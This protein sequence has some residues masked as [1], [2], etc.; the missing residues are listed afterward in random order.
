MATDANTWFM[1]RLRRGGLPKPPKGEVDQDSRSMWLHSSDQD[2]VDFFFSERAK[3]GA[4]IVAYEAK[5]QLKPHQIIIAEDGLPAGV[6]YEGRA[7]FFVKTKDGRIG[8]GLDCSERVDFGTVATPLSGLAN[9]L[10]KVYVPTL[11]PTA[12]VAVVSGAMAAPVASHTREFQAS[13]QKFAAHTE[14]TLQQT[15]G[16]VT[17]TVPD[18][19][20]D[21]PAAVT[22]DW[23]ICSKLEVALEEW[24][25]VIS[26][27][28]G[29]ETRKQPQ[30]EGPLS[31]IEFWQSRNGVLSSLTEQL[32]GQS[33]GKMLKVLELVEASSLPSFK[34]HYSELT[35]LYIEA[36]D[37]VK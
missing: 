24:I 8:D 34:F 15:S 33:I 20:I 19:V 16:D 7:M 37:N 11:C 1:T 4:T 26:S 17:L 27:T 2:R 35:R 12:P 29:Q 25:K 23:N 5:Q 10:Q 18:V 3:T 32:N 28:V 31:E 14:Q 36:K 6:E 13:L 22:D 21:D 9:L 30:G